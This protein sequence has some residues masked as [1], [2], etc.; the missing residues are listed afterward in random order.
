MAR[1][2]NLSFN[3]HKETLDIMPFSKITNVSFTREFTDYSSITLDPNF[4]R[5]NQKLSQMNKDIS[6]QH[7][8]FNFR[9][10]TPEN[11]NKKFANN[12]HNQVKVF[13]Q[14]IRSLNA[15]HFQLKSLLQD[16]AVEFDVICLSEVW[17][18]NICFLENIIPNYSLE[19]VP[20][21]DSTTGGV[22]IFYKSSYKILV[23]NDLSNVFKDVNNDI[24][25]ETL[26]ADIKFNNIECTIGVIY[27]HPKG[28]VRKFNHCINSVLDTIHNSNIEL[29]FMAG[30]FNIDL[31]KY[32][33][34]YPSQEFLDMLISYTFLP[35][36]YSPTRVTS[37][38][39]TLIDN[40]FCYQKKPKT[41]QI[42][43]SGNIYS[44][45]S[46]HFPNFLLLNFPA[47]IPK[48]TPSKIRI[49]SERNCKKFLNKLKAIDWNPVISINSTNSA[50]NSFS[51]T[52][53]ELHNS[54]FP[55]VTLSKSR[56]N[57]KPWIT[58]GL[59]ISCSTKNRLYK[60]FLKGSVSKSVYTTYRNIHNQLILTCKNDY[61]SNLF[62]E[63][64]TGIKNMWKNM[65]PILNPRKSKAPS[66]I[67][68]LVAN[69]INIQDDQQIANSLNEHFTSIGPKLAEK[70]PKSQKSFKTFL[71]NPVPHSFFMSPVSETY[72]IDLI[73]S[74]QP[75]KAPGFDEVSNKVLKLSSHFIVKPLTHI[76]NL[77][78][79][80]GV[81][82]DN[83][84]IAKIIPLYKKGDKFLGSNYRPI[85]LLP[86]FHKILEKIMKNRLYDFLSD[87]NILYEFQFGFRKNRSTNLALLDVVNDIYSNLDNK[88]FGIG[89]Y[90]DLQKAFDTVNHEILLQKLEHY[91]IRGQ[92]NKWFTSYLTNRYQYTYTNEASSKRSMVEC[93]VPQGSVLG[94]LLFILYIKD[95][96]HALDKGVPKLFA[97]DA[98]LFLF[99]EDINRLFFNANRELSLLGD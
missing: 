60:R 80:N 48:T 38:T 61:Y 86:A 29:C 19:Y 24:L 34:F 35:T 4:F 11:F 36:I 32:D 46:D 56:K 45:I 65:G 6:K 53:Y 5:M 41:N 51:D 40:I 23:R 1:S 7:T 43:F 52:F 2:S 26:W 82:P 74:L 39:A 55:K 99:S 64:I 75:N 84:K 22:G 88:K 96:S 30:D 17:A 78:F 31:I 83:L 21:V 67:Y 98:N 72:V 37:H 66:N 12:T 28:N 13:H 44:D 87:N 69:G 27:R 76:I 89:I 18:T 33:D 68:K 79:L 91:G 62:N 9:Y 63:K 57:D 71:K 95:I 15:H 94:P 16:L 81:F 20:P 73:N 3:D 25:T 92:A 10:Y 8:E 42:I 49:Y 58:K 54:C 97:D 77:S 93:G 47:K 90:L 70:L 59:R 14:N 50:F 85:S